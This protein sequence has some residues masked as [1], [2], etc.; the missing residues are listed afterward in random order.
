MNK[1]QVKQGDQMNLLADGFL[2]YLA[3][4]IDS[5]NV[6][7]EDSEELNLTL[8][9]C[10]FS[11]EGLEK[12]KA[13]FLEMVENKA[14]PANWPLRAGLA[15]LLQIYYPLIEGSDVV[16][17]ALERIE[18]LEA[19]IAEAEAES[20]RLANENVAR[21]SKQHN[22]DESVIT[23]L[24]NQSDSFDELEQKLQQATKPERAPRRSTVEYFLEELNED[25]AF[26]GEEPYIDPRMRKYLNYL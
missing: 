26:A 14:S 21:L 5:K 7:N 17:G 18:E 6:A 2:N 25:G 1:L 20:L 22:L 23:S 3:Q 13:L 11:G 10:G 16:G 4:T 19:Q 9:Q 12:A 8:E 15:E 24:W